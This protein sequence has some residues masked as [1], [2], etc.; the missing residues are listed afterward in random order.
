M[1]SFHPCQHG[2]K[3]FVLRRSQGS[4]VVE[5]E[6]AW[7]SYILQ[8]KTFS[9]G[10]TSLVVQWLKICPAMQGTWVRSLVGDLRSHM[11]WGNRSESHNWR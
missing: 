10:R 5:E 1:D 3:G 2:G 8:S 9:H 11:P 6:V 4:G 7:P